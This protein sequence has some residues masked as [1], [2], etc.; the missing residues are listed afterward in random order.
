VKLRRN[1]VPDQAILACWKHLSSIHQFQVQA[2][3][4]AIAAASKKSTWLSLPIGHKIE[5]RFV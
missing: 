4:I 2:W 1:K 3:P 5:F